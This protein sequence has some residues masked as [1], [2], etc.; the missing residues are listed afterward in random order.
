M[1]GDQFGFSVSFIS[2]GDTVAIGG[3][4][5]GNGKGRVRVSRYISG[6]WEELGPAIDGVHHEDNLGY[7]VS[8]LDIDTETYVAI[9]APQ[10]EGVGT[11]RVYEYDA[12]A[13]SLIGG[14]YMGEN[15]GRDFGFSISLAGSSKCSLVL[16]VADPSYSDISAFLFFI[17][18]VKVLDFDCGVSGGSWN[19]RGESIS[20]QSFNAFLGSAVALSSDGTTL[21]ASSPKPLDIV[22]VYEIE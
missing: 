9:G 13:W 2:N 22:L 18:N 16:A 10:E 21:A 4:N 12:N 3:P 17:G 14:T 7:S 6:T 5:H 15:S 19:Q 8:L 11:V 1:D 20:G